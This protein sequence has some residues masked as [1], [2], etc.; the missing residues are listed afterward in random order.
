MLYPGELAGMHIDVYTQQ[1]A[2]I[3]TPSGIRILRHF[4]LILKI[5]ALISR[6][7]AILVTRS[8][9]PPTVLTSVPPCLFTISRGRGLATSYLRDHIE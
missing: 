9:A 2:R 3:L 8:K 1:L 6:Y 4:K 7:T 5:A